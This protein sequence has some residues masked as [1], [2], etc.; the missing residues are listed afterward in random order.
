[1]AIDSLS[2]AR[3]AVEQERL[4]EALQTLTAKQ[5]FVVER[6]W[7]LHDNTEYS[8]REI[9]EAMGVDVKT[10]WQHHEAAM[11]RLHQQLAPFV[12][13]ESQSVRCEEAA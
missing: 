12:Y 4:A 2:I 8:Y 6:L 13:E 7:A 5:R 11:R 10:V 1:M 9:A 3:R